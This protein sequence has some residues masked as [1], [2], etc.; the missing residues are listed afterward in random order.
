MNSGMTVTSPNPVNPSLVAI[1]TTT[2]S[3][4]LKDP[5]GMSMPP[6]IGTFLTKTST[7]LSR[8]R[9]ARVLGLAF[10]LRYSLVPVVLSLIRARHSEQHLLLE[11]PAPDR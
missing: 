5:I 1:L 3:S 2:W 11:R 6:R 7:A 4:E 8:T 9:L 10:E